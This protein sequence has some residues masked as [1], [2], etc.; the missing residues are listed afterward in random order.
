MRTEK[1]AT[2]YESQKSNGSIKIPQKIFKPA[3]KIKKVEV[4]PEKKDEPILKLTPFCS[5]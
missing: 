1:K 3:E 2:S 5:K 4:K